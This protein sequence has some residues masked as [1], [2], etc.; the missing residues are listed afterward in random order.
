MKK[1]YNEMTEDEKAIDNLEGIRA[2]F[3]FFTI[4]AVIGLFS[5]VIYG[6]IASKVFSNF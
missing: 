3:K 2:M 6:V 1:E 4:L 5:C